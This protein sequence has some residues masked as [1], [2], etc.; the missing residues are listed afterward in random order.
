MLCFDNVSSKFKFILIVRINFDNENNKIK[1][2]PVFF[3]G[4]EGPNNNMEQDWMYSIYV[5]LKRLINDDHQAHESSK[6]SDFQASSFKKPVFV[7][8]FQT[9]KQLKKH[10]STNY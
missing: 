7:Q 4:L 3:A 5:H 10:A 8:A 9:L 2:Q 6:R 1:S